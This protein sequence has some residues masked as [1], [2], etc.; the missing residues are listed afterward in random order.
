MRR[1]RGFT[2]AAMFEYHER[3][4][5]VRFAEALMPKVANGIHLDADKG[6]AR[7]EN[8][9]FEVHGT[10]LRHQEGIICFLICESRQ[11]G[12]LPRGHPQFPR[13]DNDQAGYHGSSAANNGQIRIRREFRAAAE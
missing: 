13:G 9:D 11:H 6:R 4:W 12:E 7:A 2:F 1:T 3:R 8:I 10:V 5:A